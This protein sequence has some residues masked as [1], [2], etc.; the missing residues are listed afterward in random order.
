MKRVHAVHNHALSNE[1]FSS[2]G[3]YD[4]YEIG[5]TRHHE[6]MQHMAE[7]VKQ[8]L[9]HTQYGGN[10]CVV[11]RGIGGDKSFVF[12]DEEELVTFLRKSELRKDEDDSQCEPLKNKLWSEVATVWNLNENFVGSFRDDYQIIQNSYHEEGDRTCWS[13]KYS[14]VIINPDVPCERSEKFFTMQPI[15]DYVRW[16]HTGGEM[17]HLPLEKLQKL[18]TEVVDNTPAAFLPS[19]ILELTSEVFPHGVEKILPCIAFISWCTEEDVNVF[20]EDFKEKNDKAFLNDKEREY[21]SQHELYHQ[22]SKDEVQALCRQKKLPVEGKK[23]TCVKRLVEKMECA[24]PKPLNAY[25]GELNSVPE[26][27]TE[28]S[29]LSV[30]NLHEI[31]RFHNILDC[32]T[33]DELIIRVGMLKSGRGYLAFHKEMEAM[34]DLVAAITSIIAAQKLMYLQDPRILHKRRKFSQL[35]QQV[36]WEARWPHG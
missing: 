22:K 19:K 13:D 29:K 8:C 28:I 23:H 31:L 27:I 1:Q 10:P 6:N 25:S 14:T 24:P 32:G 7:E 33:K 20:L 26:S 30:Y 18:E 4:D 15:P 11:L 35:L 5:D 3:V 16:L 34:V 9:M 36:L 21:W 12:Q 2:K 17:H